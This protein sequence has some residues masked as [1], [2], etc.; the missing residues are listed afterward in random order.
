MDFFGDFVSILLYTLWIFVFV[1]VIMLI[2]RIFMDIFRDEELSGWGKFGWTILVIL[3][4]LLG[5]LIYLIAR[6]D[7]MTKR[8]IAE[9]QAMHAAQVE[10][11]RSLVAETSG[12][13][14]DIKAA[15]ALLDAGT[16]NEAD[17]EKLKAK[18]LA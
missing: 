15:Q 17:F 3:L 8:Q 13:A 6:G 14:A 11:T 2:V 12:P 5:S 10:Y 9:A 16:I 18:A 1:A 4:P 7:G